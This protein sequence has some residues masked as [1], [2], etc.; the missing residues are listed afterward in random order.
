M[1][2]QYVG[3]ITSVD[4]VYLLKTI[5]A[6]PAYSRRQRLSHWLGCKYAVPGRGQPRC[7][8]LR[9]KALGAENV[10]AISLRLFLR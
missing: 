4:A 2:E 5:P 3:S 6:S 8:S 7:R 9:W 10:L 1:K